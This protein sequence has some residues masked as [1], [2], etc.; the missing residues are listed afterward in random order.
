MGWAFWQKRRPPAK[1]SAPDEESTPVG[2]HTADQ[3]GGP[4][5]CDAFY[6]CPSVASQIMTGEEF[7]KIM[8]DTGGSIVAKRNVYVL[9]C[10]RFGAGMVR[11]WATREVTGAKATI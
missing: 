8:E 4:K 9:R 10:C 3:H 11:V 6:W 7:H 5:L 1:E 2:E